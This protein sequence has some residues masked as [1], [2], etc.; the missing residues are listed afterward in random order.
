[1]AKHNFF[2]PSFTRFTIHPSAVPAYSAWLLFH[3]NKI[4]LVAVDDH[5]RPLVR[6]IYQKEGN[7]LYFDNFERMSDIFQY[8]AKKRQPFVIIEG[9]DHHVTR[10]AWSEVLK[11]SSYRG[12]N[13]P[14]LWRYLHKHCAHSIL[15]ELMGCD[16]LRVE[17]YCFFANISIEHYQYQ[18]QQRVMADDKKELGLSQNMDWLND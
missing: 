16:Y 6:I 15:K 14:L 17:D 11:L 2:N 13:H 9:N 1:M 5:Y 12:I 8:E 4:N 18:Y 3:V 10:I 7:Y